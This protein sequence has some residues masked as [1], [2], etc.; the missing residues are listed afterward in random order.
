MRN[1][2]MSIFWGVLSRCVTLGGIYCLSHVIDAIFLS[3]SM[4]TYTI[5][6][7]YLCMERSEIRLNILKEFKNPKTLDHARTIFTVVEFNEFTET[8][9]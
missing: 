2:T 6:I 5:N 9:I 8:E 3:T 1:N 4:Q 7:R